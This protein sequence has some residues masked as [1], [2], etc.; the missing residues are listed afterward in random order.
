MKSTSQYSCRCHLIE[1]RPPLRR[2]LQTPANDN[3]AG[4][5]T[6]VERSPSPR[7]A[8]RE[9][10][11]PISDAV[12][13]RRRH[14]ATHALDRSTMTSVSAERN[15]GNNGPGQTK[16]SS[17]LTRCTA[18]PGSGSDWLVAE[19]RHLPGQSI[20][21]LPNRNLTLLRDRI[22]SVSGGSAARVV[23]GRAAAGGDP[24]RSRTT[25][26]RQIRGER[27]GCLRSNRFP[28]TLITT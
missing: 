27:Q 14:E 13:L 4:R 23:G 1:A 8:V 5:T 20:R 6:H 2:P 19:R 15:D 28:A 18:Q 11:V 22:E 12:P 16:S 9:L 25:E 3:L 26:A 24:L 10:K 21:Q 17:R 7:S